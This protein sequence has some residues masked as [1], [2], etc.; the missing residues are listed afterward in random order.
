MHNVEHLKEF[1]EKFEEIKKMGWI[2]T[3]RSG[4]TGIGKTLEDLLGITEN[5]IQGPDFG[6]YELKSGRI[7][8]NS[9]LT[10]MT[11]S[12]EPRG[13]NSVLLNKFGYHSPKSKN[14][15]EKVLHTT[16]KSGVDTPIADT[17]NTL[18]PEYIE[19]FETIHGPLEALTLISNFGI[20]EPYWPIE[21][22][23]QLVAQKL[24]NSFIYVR[25]ENRGKGKNE[26]FK[27]TE[28]YLLKG[29]DDENIIE[30]IRRGIIYIDIRI[31]QYADGSTHDHGTGFRIKDSDQHLLYSEKIRLDNE[32]PQA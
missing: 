26:E 19:A 10:L 12:P 9:M 29:I 2:K 14:P 8:S 15:K 32:N 27:Y 22:I 4:N 20:E 3:H 30:L 17:G 5:N 31:G 6:S 7:N 21:T 16:L 18:R 25:A 23:K 28:A 13:I 11:K 1:I 24:G